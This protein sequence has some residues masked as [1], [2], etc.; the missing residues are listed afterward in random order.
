MS[1]NQVLNISVSVSTKDQFSWV[2]ILP[3]T[4]CTWLLLLA[5]N[6]HFNPDCFLKPEY[7]PF[8]RYSSIAMQQPFI[9]SKIWCGLLRNDIRWDLTYV[10]DIPY[11]D[12]SEM[13]LKFAEELGADHTVLA[14][15]QDDRQMAERIISVLGGEPD[16]SIECSG[17]QSA[18]RMAIFVCT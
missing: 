12:I 13:R 18:V 3:T 9:Q 7:L 8:W 15:S 1:I 10:T 17:A 6:H 5:S 2:S 11:I 16:I 4:H 14:D